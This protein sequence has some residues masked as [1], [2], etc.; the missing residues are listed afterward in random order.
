[1]HARRSIIQTMN[2]KIII[3]INSNNNN[4]YFCTKCQCFCTF[5]CLRFQFVFLLPC[6]SISCWYFPFSHSNY[7][8]L[9]PRISRSFLYYFFFLFSFFSSSSPFFLLLNGD[10]FKIF[11]RSLYTFFF[12]NA[13]TSPTVCILY[14]LTTNFWY[15]F[16]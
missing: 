1:M 11:A 7:Y 3:I 9:Y 6:W 4:F 5:P 13:H 16:I 15:A 8:F 10:H 14:N 2:D 12:A